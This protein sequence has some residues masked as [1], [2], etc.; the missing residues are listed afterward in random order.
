MFE[1]RCVGKVSL[2]RRHFS[3]DLNNEKEL[4]LW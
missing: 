1:I 2:S 4:N 3:K